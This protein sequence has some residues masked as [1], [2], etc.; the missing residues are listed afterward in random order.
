M[1]ALALCAPGLRLC[2][3]LSLQHASPA[4]ARHLPCH[5]ANS[6]FSVAFSGKASGLPT[7]RWRHP[8]PPLRSWPS[9]KALLSESQLFWRLPSQHDVLPEAEPPSRVL[10][11]DPV[12]SAQSGRRMTEA[13]QKGKGPARAPACS[14]ALPWG[15]EN[16]VPQRSG[17][18]SEGAVCKVGGVPTPPSK[19]CSRLKVSFGSTQVWHCLLGGGRGAHGLRVWSY[20]TSQHTHT[21][22]HFRCQSQVQAVTCAPEVPTTPSWFDQFAR[23]VHRT[24]RLFF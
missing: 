15:H 17:T 13:A 20:K 24:Q 4:P 22:T 6:S 12:G 8:L 11:H 2:C 7:P 1:D 16:I 9:A 14:P 5:P 21:H 19:Q 23:A 3:N 18:S 10:P